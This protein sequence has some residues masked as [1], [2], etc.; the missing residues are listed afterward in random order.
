MAVSLSFLVSGFLGEASRHTSV[1]CRPLH[2][3][4]RPTVRGVASPPRRGM[5]VEDTLSAA[6]GFRDLRVPNIND[7][8]H[9]PSR[10]PDYSR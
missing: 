8:A 3:H 2:V 6:Q 7:T 4:E 1:D 10:L 5:D 9:R